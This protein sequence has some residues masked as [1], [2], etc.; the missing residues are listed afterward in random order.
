[1]NGILRI[2]MSVGFQGSEVFLSYAM[3]HTYLFGRYQVVG[4]QLDMDQV[5]PDPEDEIVELRPHLAG[6][7][8]RDY[9]SYGVDTIIEGLRARLVAPPAPAPRT[10]TRTARAKS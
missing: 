1:M 8:G 6:L 3:I 10:K 7:H 4:F 2:L 9:F 5:P